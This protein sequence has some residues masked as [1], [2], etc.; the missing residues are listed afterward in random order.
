M[1]QA[2]NRATGI[3]RKTLNQLLDL[4]VVTVSGSNKGIG[5]DSE[6]QPWCSYCCDLGHGVRADCGSSHPSAGDGHVNRSS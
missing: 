1:N 2:V 6:G 4:R 5:C 3:E